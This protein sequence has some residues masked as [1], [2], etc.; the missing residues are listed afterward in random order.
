[1]RSFWTLA[2]LPDLVD[3]PRF[4]SITTRADNFDAL[5]RIAG[6]ALALL[7]LPVLLLLKNFF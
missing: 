7:S 1:V 3:D 2:G 6:E 5:Y 4:V